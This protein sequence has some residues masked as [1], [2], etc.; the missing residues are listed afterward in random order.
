MRGVLQVRV[1]L[2]SLS[3]RFQSFEHGH[4]RQGD[5]LA[6]RTDGFERER[7]WHLL[8]MLLVP[9]GHGPSDVGVDRIEVPPAV[10]SA[11]LLQVGH[12][13]LEA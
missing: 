6:G 11:F 5:Q 2:G 7:R 1:D 4:R 10:R 12:G 9:L 3:R 8:R 13:V